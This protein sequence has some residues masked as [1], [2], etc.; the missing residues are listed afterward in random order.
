V[1]RSPT[2]RVAIISDIHYAGP[3]ESARRT[4]LLDPITNPLRRWL[5]RA[6]VHRSL[7]ARRTRER[8]ARWEVA[9]AR[10]TP[11]CTLC[12][13]ERRA[14]AAQ[15][16]DC[17]DRIVAELSAEHRDV[18]LLRECAGLDYHDISEQLALPLGTV[19]SRLNRARA[20]VR[21]SLHAWAASPPA[22][23]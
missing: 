21:D 23:Q 3:A 15:F 8:R 14:D 17:L 2:I 12:D 1:T 19:R 11:E 16:W 9:A 5:V 13:P 10:E 22:V 6:V 18:W 4:A 7:H 20:R